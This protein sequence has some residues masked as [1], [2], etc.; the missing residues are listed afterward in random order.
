MSTKF[1]IAFSFSLICF[2]A[3]A[4]TPEGVPKGAKEIRPGVY[5]AI[6][7]NGKAWTYRKTPFGFQKSAEEAPASPEPAREE[8]RPKTATPFGESKTPPTAVKTTVTEDGDT[9]RF[10]RP[11]PFGTSRWTRKK[12]ELTEE[13]KRIWEAHQASAKAANAK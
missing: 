3:A 12:S 13:E 7:N 9:L 10:E 1:A 6:D 2:T 8:I 5:R 4:Q 11:N